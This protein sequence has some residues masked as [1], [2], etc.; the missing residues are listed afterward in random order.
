MSSDPSSPDPLGT[1]HPAPAELVAL[2]EQAAR[3]AGD[4]VRDQRPD[5]L[6]V[7]STKTSPTDVVTAMDTAAEELL[8]ER[9]LTVRP[10]DGLLGEEGGLRPGTSGLTWVVDPI[11]G[12]VNYLYRIPAYAVSVAVVEGEPDPRTWRVLAGCVHNPVSGETWTASVGGGAF[13]SGRRLGVHDGVELGHA[14]VGTGFGY[15]SGRRRS[16]ARVLAALL[17]RLRDV[18]RAGA[19]SLDLCAVASGRLDAYYERGLKPWDLAAGGLVATEAGASV[20]GL[21]GLSASED[22]VVAAAPALARRL[23]QVLSGLDPLDDGAPQDGARP[24]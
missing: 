8:V 3:A 18:R 12:T 22:M 17:P 4:L 24:A 1:A 10:D 23:Q 19:A 5:D 15:T 9:L 14:L 16:Q 7:A 2:A 20:T 13:L 21:G 6:G 11:D